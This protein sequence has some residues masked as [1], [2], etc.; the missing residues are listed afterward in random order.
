MKKSTKLLSLLLALLMVCSVFAGCANQTIDVEKPDK[1]GEPVD[2]DICVMKVDGLSENFIMGVD[3]STQLALEES[4]V[5]YYNW[6]GSAEQDIFITLAQAGINTIR[7]RVWNDPYDENGNPYG[8]GN[9]T[10]DTAIE[11]GK[12]AK[13]VGIG[14]IIDFHYS[15]FWADPAKQYSPKAWEGMDSETRTT[16]LYEY[17]KECLEKV[18]KAGIDVYGV[19]IGN[20]TNTAMAG[21]SNSWTRVCKMFNAGSKAVREVFPEA[22]VILHFTDPQ[23]GHYFEKADSLNANGVDYDVFASSYYPAWHGSLENLAGQFQYIIDTYGKEVMVA[24]TA[25]AYTMEDGDGY[26]NNFS[27]SEDKYPISVQGQAN[28]LADLIGAMSALGDKCLGVLYWEPAWIPLHSTAYL[29]GE[30]WQTNYDLNKEAWEKYGTGWASQWAGAYDADAA[31]WYGGCSVENLALFGY[32]GIP[33]ESLKTFSYVYTGTTAEVS[34]VSV[35]D[36]TVEVQ[37]GSEFV[38]PETLTARCND[39]SEQQIPVEWNSDELALITTDQLADFTVNGV[40][41][42][43]DVTMTVLVRTLNLVQCPGFEGETYVWLVE[44]AA[45]DHD[46]STDTPHSGEKCFHFWDANDNDARI[47]QQIT[48]PASGTYRLSATMQGGENGMCKEAY[49]FIT[50][51]G[52]TTIEHFPAPMTGWNVW[53]TAYLND[54]VL[55]EGQTVTIGAYVSFSA[56]GWGTI[57]DFELC[58][59]D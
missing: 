3:I 59:S 46:F 58:L 9:C 49:I 55:K 10:I 41:G 57:D 17:T 37:K 45:S 39:M 40:C 38:A 20:E 15:D 31:E 8:A 5:K 56:G 50:V 33:L 16:A 43:V 23:R 34:V 42:G 26:S 12:R 28:Q 32:D 4:G 27:G 21:V 35:P 47:S 11:L 36:I 13:A 6:D 25:W 24:E 48:V 52:V 29:T 54:I 1:N 2:S 30:E 7:V 18:K 53:S 51:D 19:Q 22:K 14:L 44:S